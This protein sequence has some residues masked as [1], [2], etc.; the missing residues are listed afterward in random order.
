MLRYAQRSWQ[1][2]IR[3]GARVLVGVA[4][5]GEGAAAN[6]DT[7]KSCDA[8]TQADQGEAAWRQIRFVWEIGWG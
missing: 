2:E 4:V 6:T 8:C 7:I 3:G 5:F 1:A